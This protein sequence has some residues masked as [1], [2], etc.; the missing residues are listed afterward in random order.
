MPAL[1]SISIKALYRQQQVQVKKD[2]KVAMLWQ[3]A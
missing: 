3:K 1:E 2:V